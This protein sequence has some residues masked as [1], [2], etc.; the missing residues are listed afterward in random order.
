MIGTSLFSSAGIAEY[1]LEDIG[2]NITVA[3]EIVV[4]RARLY[5]SIYP[6]SKMIQGNIL[7]PIIFKRILNSSNDKLD[8]L[9]ASPPCQGMS[10]AGKNRNIEQMLTDDRNFL[11][12]KIIEYLL[13]NEINSYPKY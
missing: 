5:Q 3:N 9:L 7:D 12:F 2:L 11:V 8:F 4:E 6:N 1:Y 13:P 10:V